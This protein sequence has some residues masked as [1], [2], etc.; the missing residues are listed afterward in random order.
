MEVHWRMAH[1]GARSITESE[2]ERVEV[3]FLIQFR[4]NSCI[5]VIFLHFFPLLQQGVISVLIFFFSN[6]F[7]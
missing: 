3:F 2:N 5:F 1:Y 6:L 4:V 7:P